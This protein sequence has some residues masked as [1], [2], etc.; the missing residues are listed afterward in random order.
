MNSATFHQRH[1]SVMTS[2]DAVVTVEAVQLAPLV[3]V[4]EKGAKC[5]LLVNKWEAASVLRVGG[6]Q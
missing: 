6:G 5:C 2:A 1:L 3:L 4:S